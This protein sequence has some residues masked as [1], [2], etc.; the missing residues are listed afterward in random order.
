MRLGFLFGKRFVMI[1]HRGRKS[2]QL[3]RT[4]LEVAGH[5]A[6]PGSFVVT[7]GTGPRADW[8]RNISANGV[9][10][11]WVGSARHPATVT[12]LEPEES[13]TVFARYEAEHPKTA[14]KLMKSMGVSYDGTDVGRVEMMEHIPMVEFIV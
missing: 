5:R 9:D 12:F 14:T 3:Y 13:A 1:E 10:G 6:T 11:V 2:G 4:V 8:Y 7:S